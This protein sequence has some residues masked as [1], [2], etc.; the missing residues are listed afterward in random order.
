MKATA[1]D[2]LNFT[3]CGYSIVARRESS[4]AHGIAH[5]KPLVNLVAH[6]PQG[7]FDTSGS[8]HARRSTVGSRCEAESVSKTGRV[9]NLNHYAN[10]S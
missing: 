6:L 7:G 10:V 9:S 5:T 2:V 3:P 1:V 4:P 8:L